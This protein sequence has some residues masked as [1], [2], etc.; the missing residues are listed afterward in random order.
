MKKKNKI[1][2]L[3]FTIPIITIGIIFALA[4][5]FPF[6]NK[7]I[8]I[9]DLSTQY[10]ELMEYLKNALLGKHS[11]FYSFNWGM[12]KSLVGT[13]AYI[14]SSPVNILLIFYPKT[15]IQL[16]IF[17]ITLIKYGLIGLSFNFFL[18]KKFHTENYNTILFSLCYSLMAYN[19]SYTL[20]I[21]WL[22]GVF[23]LPIV[24]G[25]LVEM[26]ETDKKTGLII[27]LTL[28]IISQ[29]YMAYIVILFSI[30]YFWY[31]IFIKKYNIN[32][33]EA[34]LKFFKYIGLIELSAAI[35]A[36]LTLPT[37]LSLVRENS[38]Q[39]LLTFNINYEFGDILSKVFIGSFDTLRTFG[40]PN[41]YC[42]I[43]IIILSIGYFLSNKVNKKEKIFS[44][45]VLF[46]MYASLRLE[47]L[48]MIW[49]AFDKPNW[50]PAR[51]SF[52]I[53]F[54]LIY[55][56]YKFYL[57]LNEML[58]KNLIISII[59]VLIA[60]VIFIR[61][62]YLSIL[63]IKINLMFLFSYLII[64]ILKINRKK[65]EILFSILVIG[66]LVLNATMIQ[67]D[68]D[69]S[70]GYVQ[71]DD[72][73]YEK[74]EIKEAI[75]TI[76]SQD[77]GIYRIEKDFATRYNNGLSNDY[78]TLD[79]YSSNYNRELHT[80]LRH[81][82]LSV[83][84]KYGRYAGTTMISDA[85]LGIKYVISNKGNDV[86]PLIGQTDEYDIYKNDNAFPLIFSVNNNIMN[87]LPYE[88][89]KNPFELQTD[90]INKLSGKN[91][92]LFEK[93]NFVS[94][95]IVNLKTI[96]LKN[97]KIK[98][99]K[100]DKSKEAYIKYT[101]NPKNKK[102]L[103]YLYIDDLKEIVSKIYLKINDEDV[104]GD[105]IDQGDKLI[106]IN[107]NDRIKIIIDTDNL[108]MN[109]DKIYELNREQFEN[110]ITEIKKIN[111]TNFIKEM[112]DGYVKIKSDT[113]QE[114]I[115]MTTIPYEKGWKLKI[116]GK[117]SKIKKIMG[118]FIGIS[119]EKGTNII[120]L[121][122]E[123]PGLKIGILVSLITII[124]LV[125]IKIY[126]YKNFKSKEVKKNEKL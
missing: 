72:Y 119:L 106:K 81:L 113:N 65:K 94:E 78:M 56:A 47:F 13:I 18:Y 49:H 91:Y 59:S 110:A 31:E 75:S 111:N 38:M 97:E 124:T 30:V 25:Y 58:S 107:N 32:L 12:G 61:R 122:Y 35:S 121:K 76:K 5:I 55:I 33:K 28:L 16:V 22:D 1:F 46:I 74:K 84:D 60:S 2:L 6:G 92:K 57:T 95:K 63:D 43:I 120:E 71:K 7:S 90:I 14:L 87:M 11:F 88:Q 85:F 27:S 51:F 105:I 15:D 109:R 112:K 29:F 83:F 48:Y 77:K 36:F 98:Y 50:F 8:L 26:I 70:I 126:K 45:L 39:S 24:L 108:E 114:K 89:Y 44:F 100:I 4:S 79:I 68:L 37:Y 3:S 101:I 93:I 21:M 17:I 67:H 64:F 62:E 54:F 123:V 80:F 117:P 69:S 99:E 103:T 20:N 116:N 125:F 52:A 34:F 96:E 10:V 23:L 53:C 82:G 66:E 104:S 115:L 41:L 73:I 102:N 86:Y 40:T 19:I 9:N 42:G 118:I